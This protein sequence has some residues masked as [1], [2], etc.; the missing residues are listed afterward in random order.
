MGIIGQ[1]GMATAVS[2]VL[3]VL[4]PLVLIFVQ[5]EVR[6]RRIR[7]IEEFRRNFFYDPKAAARAERAASER[8]K[9]EAAAKAE[10]TRE[11]EAPLLEAIV[12][13]TVLRSAATE[14]ARGGK[15]KDC[16]KRSEPPTKSPSFE[17]VVTKYII[18]LFDLCTDEQRETIRRQGASAL[19]SEELY[20]LVG[21]T[22]IWKVASNWYLL[23]AFLP[24]AIAVTGITFFVLEGIGN[25]QVVA[26]GGKD[27]PVY[28]AAGLLGATFFTLRLLIG[29]AIN[30]DLTPRVPVRAFG[31]FVLVT[32]VMA[33]Y[34]R[35]APPLGEA[36]PE[37]GWGQVQSLWGLAVLAGAFVIGVQP[38]A[39][40][41]FV[42]TVGRQLAAKSPLRS[43]FALIKRTDNRFDEHV[44][45]VP[46][47]VL[48]G[49]DFGTRYRL[50]DVGL[51]DV[52]NLAT[53]NPILLHIETPYGIYQTVD[54]VAQAQLCTIVGL[55]RFM[56]FQQ[57]S[58][59]TIF[60]LERM[61]LSR[62]STHALRQFA[63]A[64]LF[65]PNG[66]LDAV[67]KAASDPGSP[68]RTLAP[69]PDPTR[70]APLPAG[71]AAA[72]L[73]TVAEPADIEEEVC[74]PETCEPVWRAAKAVADASIIHAV[75]VMVD[76]L[77]VHRLREIWERI[78]RSLGHD[79]E[80][81]DDS[82]DAALPRDE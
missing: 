49:I 44:G 52:Q 59:R 3:A 76:D 43:V 16:C 14:A 75:R 66:R 23:F 56:I 27:L 81:L 5:H 82:F 68:A 53:A 20:A 51:C 36:T 6:I 45:I 13:E 62:R 60:D 48:D 17:F 22:R 58:I 21:R 69:L 11:V 37:T 79:A 15:R 7:L 55:E 64:I 47:E 70:A 28:L 71:F 12:A 74:D 8:R 78:G 50:E 77:H 67:L 30:F 54:W 2:L 10:E 1:I 40:F 72:V 73:E 26:L 39:G 80:H 18:D 42:Y 25:P 31:Q 65:T 24:Y 41:Q 9:R 34:G 46:L 38:E 4:L 61:V 33:V 35:I 19:S 63:G 32:V 29:S 57:F